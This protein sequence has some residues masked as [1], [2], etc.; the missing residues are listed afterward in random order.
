VIWEASRWDRRAHP[1]LPEG[2]AL[3]GREIVCRNPSRPEEMLY[4]FTNLELAPE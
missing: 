4:L 3:A 1:Q 2:A